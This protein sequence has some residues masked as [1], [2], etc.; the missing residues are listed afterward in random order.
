MASRFSRFYNATA[1]VAFQTGDN[2]EMGVDTPTRDSYHKAKQTYTTPGRS[3]TSRGE[4]TVKRTGKLDPLVD[5]AGYGVIRPSRMRMEELPS[6]LW[7]VSVGAPA[8]Q[9]NRL[10]TT[11]SMGTNV[12][13]AIKVLPDIFEL[14]AKV[15]PGRD[16]F[17]CAS[18]FGDQVDQFILQRGQFEVLADRMVNQLTLMNP[19]GMGGANN[20]ED[21]H[22]GFFGAAYL[23]DAYLQRIG[24]KTMDFTIS[25]EPV[26]SPLQADQ[27][28]RVFGKE[29]FE[30]VK[31]NGYDFDAKNLPTNKEVVQDM[32]KRA[33][34]FAFLVHTDRRSNLV[35]HWQELYGK[36]HVVIM[37]NIDYMA[38][39]M[40]AITG[41]TEGTLDLQSVKDF[42]LDTEIPKREAI[43][44]VDAI[45]HIPLGAQ[46]ALPNYKLLPK[47]GD[48]FA[49]KTDLWP[50]KPEDIPEGITLGDII[51]ADAGA[52]TADSG[53][54]L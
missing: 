6:G 14:T 38:Y 27:L 49:N 13:R 52:A 37:P 36:D 30:K 23:T 24:L 21:P 10:D 25:D 47:K 32:L 45:S 48:I 51:Q 4:E 17:Y 53:G 20:G 34:A 54:W 19:E 40:A 31:E 33:H 50:M 29:V 28:V 39:M 16:P 7:Q 12:E 1:A 41:L 3:S 42:L 5:P 46:C 26:H 9:E 22:Y 43:Q 8:T 44:I 18:F 35:S 15:L 2:T 11:G